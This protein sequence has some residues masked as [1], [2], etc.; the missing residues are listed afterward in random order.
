[1][2]TRHRDG[3]TEKRMADSRGHSDNVGDIGEARWQVKRA[4]MR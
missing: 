1:M 2:G 3:F 4:S